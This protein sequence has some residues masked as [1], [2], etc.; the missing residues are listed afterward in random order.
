MHIMI[1]VVDE[2]EVSDEEREKKKAVF[3]VRRSFCPS[4]REPLVGMEGV[5]PVVA[6][7]FQ[8]S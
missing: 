7:D 2:G 4:K 6:V 3:L 5:D 8:M 1:N